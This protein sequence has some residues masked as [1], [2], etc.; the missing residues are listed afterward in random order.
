MHQCQRS[1]DYDCEG[2]SLDAYL[3]LYSDG[4]SSNPA[5]GLGQA[6]PQDPRQVEGMCSIDLIHKYL[7]Q[8]PAY[9]V[10]FQL[11]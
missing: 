5:L 2:S 10:M 3:R 7:V 4:L 1:E 9:C 8:I 11:G 6:T